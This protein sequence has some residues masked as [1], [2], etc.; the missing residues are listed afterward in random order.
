MSEDLLRKTAVVL[1]VLVCATSMA[2]AAETKIAKAKEVYCVGKIVS[3]DGMK[4]EL[5][6]LEYNTDTE[7]LFS[8]PKGIPPDLSLGQD[9]V[10]VS[11]AGSDVADSVRLVSGG[12]EKKPRQ[13]ES[14]AL[15]PAVAQVPEP[16]IWDPFD[17]MDR[18]RDQMQAMLRQAYPVNGGGRGMFKS[19]VWYEPTVD[20]KKTD[21]AYVYTFDVAGLNRKSIKVDVTQQA[22]TVSGES[23]STQ[24][25]H[26]GQVA[27]MSESYASFMKS[28]PLPQDA[29]VKHAKTEIGE[30][31]LTVTVPIK[32]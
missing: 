4:N 17:E 23:R 28:V 21:K 26:D 25:K 24:N 20:L 16:M 6:L 15:S 12:R 3:L 2:I 1:G 22:I 30:S 18:M 32:K 9:V 27:A 14:P 5:A 29:D 31:A 19:S 10:V 11:H 13:E 8:V 7:K